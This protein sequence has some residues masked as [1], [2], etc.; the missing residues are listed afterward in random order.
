MKGIQLLNDLQF[1]AK[2]P[3]ADPI[4]VD[5]NGRI[6]RFEL[7]PGQSIRQHNAPDSPFYAVVLKGSGMFAGADG[8]E[9]QFGPN[10]LLIFE[11][12]ENH[13]IRALD[14]KLVFIGFLHGAPSNVSDRVGG[15]IGH[16]SS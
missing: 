9:E 12:G 6:I 14:E 10:S 11:P 5:K 15:V 1:S 2:R 4:Y 16:H 8:K 7:E 13:A 3:D